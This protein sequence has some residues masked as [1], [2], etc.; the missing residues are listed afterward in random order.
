MLREMLKSKISYAVVTQTELYYEG[1]ITIDKDIIRSAGFLPGEK[2]EV[3]NVNNGMRF[4]TYVI[5]GSRQGEV[6]LNGPA[7]RLGVVGD[8]LIIL[9]YCLVEDKEAASFKPKK[10]VLDN[11][12][13]IKE[14]L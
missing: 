9:S 10:V 2:V 13:R 5:E 4:Y 11:N 12:N 7:A 3:L 14:S 8:E 6:C 1:S